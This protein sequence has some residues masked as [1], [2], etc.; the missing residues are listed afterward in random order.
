MYVCKPDPKALHPE[1]LSS[2]IIPFLKNAMRDKERN[3]YEKIHA[4]VDRS[5]FEYVLSVTK[6]NQSEAARV[7][8]INRLTL[9]KKLKY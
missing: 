3:I 6:E 1:T 9:R 2:A 7:L 4:E 8:G 5:V